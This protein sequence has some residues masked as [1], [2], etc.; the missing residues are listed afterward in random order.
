MRQKCKSSP[1]VSLNPFSEL[2]HLFEDIHGVLSTREKKQER[3]V[4]EQASRDID[5]GLGRGVWPMSLCFK[6]F[7][8]NLRLPFVHRLWRLGPT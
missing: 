5:V 4:L 3:F 6:L 7:A 2:F 8:P 1:S